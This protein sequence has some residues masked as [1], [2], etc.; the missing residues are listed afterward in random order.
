MGGS[1]WARFTVIL[2]A[3][4]GALY[5]L[6]PTLIGNDAQD[7]LKDQVTEVAGNEGA[8]PRRV[9]RLPLPFVA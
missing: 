6:S 3:L 9:R 7:R 8:A 4:A 5:V 2:L 1:W